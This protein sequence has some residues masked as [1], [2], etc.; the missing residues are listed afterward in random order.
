MTKELPMAIA[1]D[2]TVIQLVQIDK[3]P[4]PLPSSVACKYCY[5]KHECQETI[6][7]TEVENLLGYNC[8]DYDDQDEGTYVVY[9]GKV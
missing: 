7:S 2:G 4:E 3:E 9:W 5:V 1:P 8:A 6:G